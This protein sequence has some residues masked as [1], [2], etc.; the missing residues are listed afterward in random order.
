MEIK[1]PVFNN[2]SKQAVKNP[3]IATIQ[4][5]T[6]KIT[7]PKVATNFKKKIKY[8]ILAIL[9]IITITI[10]LIFAFAK[11]N[12]K[13]IKDIS[14]S[15]V[16]HSINFDFPENSFD[17]TIDE[18]GNKKIIIMPGNSFTGQVGM[19]SKINEEL[20]NLAGDVFVR[21]RMEAYVITKSENGSDVRNYFGNLLQTKIINDVNNDWF[22]DDKYFYYNDILKPEQS[23]SAKLDMLISHENTPNFLQSQTLYITCTF[24]VLQASAYQSINEIWVSAPYLWKNSITKK[25]IS[26]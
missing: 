22:I 20:P 25:V 24:E 18:D 7:A 5:N 21:F 16:V 15:T 13:E 14:I 1:R 9:L 26:Q 23:V 10:C 2:P 11:D 3:D 17:S 19:T 8:I 12:V 4:G 6:T